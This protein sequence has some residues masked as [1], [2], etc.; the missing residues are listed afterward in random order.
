MAFTYDLVS[1]SVS[2]GEWR[3]WQRAALNH[4]GV[5][6]G[7]CILE[8]AHGTANLQIDLKAA[9][10]QSIGYDLSRAMGRIAQAKLRRHKIAPRLVRGYAQALPFVSGAFPVVVSTFPTD[11][12]ADPA[13]LREIYRVLQ[14]GGRLVIVPGARLTRGGLARRGI[15]AAYAATGQNRPWPEKVDE[16]FET[17]G[18]QLTHLTEPC[19]RSI[20]HVLIAEKSA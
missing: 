14:P 1:W 4:L 6:R 17:I 7:V 8:L 9:G 12:I 5:A 13:T 19:P 15:D 2:L 20:V 18:F 10:Y 3:S 11:F 16:R